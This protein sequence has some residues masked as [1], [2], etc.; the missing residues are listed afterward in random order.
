MNV[1]ATFFPLI[2]V[3]QNTE[4]MPYPEDAKTFKV[5]VSTHTPDFNGIVN[6]PPSLP[7]NG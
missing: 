7:R 4:I 1:Y 2:S 3:F 5:V 6:I